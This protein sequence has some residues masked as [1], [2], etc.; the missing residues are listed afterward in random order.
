MLPSVLP[1]TFANSK[2]WKSSVEIL[3]AES[4][5]SRPTQ[6]KTGLEWATRRDGSAFPKGGS[7]SAGEG[8]RATQPGEDLLLG[9]PDVQEILVGGRSHVSFLFS[10]SAA[11]R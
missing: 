5:A 6:A 2:D 11:Q 4:W 8:A 7:K 9:I 3:R 10:S 1:P